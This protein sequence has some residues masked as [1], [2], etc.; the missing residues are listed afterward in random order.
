MTICSLG[1]EGAVCDE[2]SREEGTGQRVGVEVSNSIVHSRASKLLAVAGGKGTGMRV[3]LGTAGEESGL[4][5][6]GLYIQGQQAQQMLVMRKE[7]N[8][9]SGY[10]RTMIH[11]CPG[12]TDF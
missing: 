3:C 1:Q 7:L 5:G 11:D 6:G 12:S 9:P 2:C 10:N 8:V 4:R